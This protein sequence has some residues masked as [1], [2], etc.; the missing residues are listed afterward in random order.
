MGVGFMDDP[1]KQMT[2]EGKGDEQETRGRILAAACNLMATRGYKGATTRLIAEAAGVNEVTIFRHFGNKEGLLSAII[3]ES[4][5][6]EGHLEKS[7]Q[8]EYDTV[9]EMLVHFGGTFYQVLEDNKELLLIFLME[10]CRPDMDTAFSRVPLTAIK[11]LAGK[12]QS[13]H[14]QGQIPKSDFAI[15]AQ[16]FVSNFFYAFMLVYYIK[17]KDF[18]FDFEH[19]SH[20]TAKILMCGLKM[21][22]IP[23]NS[24]S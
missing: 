10:V 9:E 23:T 11:M 8:Q 16:M 12:L 6:V 13:L 24:S 22:E 17:Q 2:E 21:E 5:S 15:A 20:H 14:E 19:F 1:K 3:D 7:L 18:H 4:T